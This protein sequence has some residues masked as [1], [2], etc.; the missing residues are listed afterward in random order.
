MIAP[1]IEI[2][3]PT[4]AE[5]SPDKS[6]IPALLRN[7]N[8]L[9]PMPAKDNILAADEIKNIHTKISGRFSIPIPNIMRRTADI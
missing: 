9:T 3:S 8:S 7:K 1:I 5:V 6:R 4:V 2:H